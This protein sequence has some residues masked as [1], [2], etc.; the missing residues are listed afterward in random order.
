MPRHAVPV[1]ARDKQPVQG[2]HEHG[3]LDGKAELAR[4]Q[5][6]IQHR[7]D[8]ELLPQPREQQRAADP[9]GIERQA[10]VILIERLQQ[11]HLVSE[12]GA[13]SEQ[14]GQGTG[15]DQR[16]GA[17]EIGNDRLA[18][19]ATKA[20]VLDNLKVGTRP[21]LLNAEE[22]HS[23]NTEHYDI[24]ILSARKAGSYITCGTTYWQLGAS[25]SIISITYQH[26]GPIYYSTRVRAGVGLG[27]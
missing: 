8:A 21:R 18:H 11:Q 22:H 3:A 5:Q 12:L 7:A 16:L 25:A 19:G 2:R 26:I 13:R 17:A 23:S 1:G 4:R 24:I 20:V 9:L 10:G 6:A 27:P 15:R 14:C